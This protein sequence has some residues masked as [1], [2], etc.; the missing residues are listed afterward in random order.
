MPFQYIVA[1]FAIWL[2]I[3]FWLWYDVDERYAPWGIPPALILAILIVSR[4]QINWWWYNRHPP[5]LD[6]PIRR[7]LETTH[8]FYKNLFPNEQARFRRQVVMYVLY[9]QIKGIGLDELPND[10]RA[11]VA[12]K[13]VTVAFYTND[14]LLKAYDP[15]FIYGHPFPTPRFNDFHTLELD[16]QDNAIILSAPQL[17][18]GTINPRIYYDTGL[19]VFAEAFKH[20]HPEFSFPEFVAEDWTKLER[21]GGFVKHKVLSAIGLTEKEVPLWPVSA[22]TYFHFP[23]AF[24]AHWPEM[25]ARINAIFKN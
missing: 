21:I 22:V 12:I 18:A 23:T 16:T 1:P 4:R 14:P 24:R 15:V 2:A 13:A 17:M 19:H 6:E 7:L 11:A 8:T 10:L 25:Y 5:E 20:A 3:V 9:H